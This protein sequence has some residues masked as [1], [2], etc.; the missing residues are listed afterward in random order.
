MVRMRLGYASISTTR[1]DA[2]GTCQETTTPVSTN[3]QG[4]TPSQWACTTPRHFSKANPAHPLLTRH[5]QLPHARRCL[6]SAMVSPS[7]VRTCQRPHRRRRRARPVLVLRRQGT[8]CFSGHV[9][10]LLGSSS[11]DLV[12]LWAVQLSE[13]FVPTC[14]DGM[15]GWMVLHLR[16]ELIKRIYVIFLRNFS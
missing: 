8:V 12:S 5:Q 15:R 4:R 3:A 7:L 14:H 11:L 13:G 2:I 9:S 10:P 16:R 6:Q 1:W